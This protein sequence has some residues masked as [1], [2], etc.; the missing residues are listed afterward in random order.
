VCP[1]YAPC[2]IGKLVQPLNR[3]DYQPKKEPQTERH[4][5]SHGG[6]VGPQE[7]IGT[8]R[9]QDPVTKNG[10]PEFDTGSVEWTAKD[11]AHIRNE[12]SRTSY[13]KTEKS[14]TSDPLRLDGPQGTGRHR[15]E[16]VRHPGR[17]T[18]SDQ[19]TPRNGQLSKY[20]VQI[21]SSA[22]I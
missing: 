11:K 14:R 21:I 18:T 3:S 2:K 16:A 15:D 1:V 9:V 10:P 17:N 19:T 7:D 20:K 13:S 6:K 4:V 22:Q 5:E 12:K 8:V